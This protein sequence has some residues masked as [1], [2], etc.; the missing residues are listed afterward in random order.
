LRGR[1]RRRRREKEE[2][3]TKGL[4]GWRSEQ[5]RGVQHEDILGAKSYDGIWCISAGRIAPV[6]ACMCNC[7]K[8]FEEEDRRAMGGS[9]AVQAPLRRGGSTIGP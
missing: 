5:K 4:A 2:R 1:K 8:C 3:K 6:S 7:Y 9:S